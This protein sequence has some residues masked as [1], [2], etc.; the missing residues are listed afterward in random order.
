MSLKKI[1]KELGLSLTTVSRALN[2]YPEVA[3]STRL[4][5]EAAAKRHRYKPNA[6]A[7][8]LALGRADAIGLVF[9]ITPGDLGD[10]QFL[11]VA[12]SMS[13]RFAREGIDLLIISASPRDEL[14]AYE[15]AIKGRRIDAFV[16]AR[17]RVHDARLE[18]LLAHDVPFVAYG[19][20][21]ALQRPYAW[22]DFDNAAGAQM[23]AQRLLEFGHRRL[24]YLGAPPEYNFAEQR[25]GGF[26]AALQHAGVAIDDAA[27]LRLA[28]DRR[29]GYAAMQAL[30]ALPRRPSAVLVDNNLAG[31]GAVHA[32]LNAGLTLGR[33]LS[34]IVY[35]GLG[36]DSVI[37]SAITS[38]R[39]PTPSATG[40]E[41]AELTLARVRG[42]PLESLHRLKMPALDPGDSD[43]PPLQS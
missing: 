2:G 3:E 13:E 8:G 4:A 25:F 41:I 34:V 21:A 36:E 19:R 27:V 11:D 22:L 16:V 42:E 30:L 39:Q 5:V 14:A 38:I 35:D 29:S 32:L 33:D 31:V 7:R 12:A 43:G 24:G 10:A 37:R 18:L 6:I 40:T 9:P 15:R 20:S 17:T 23:A 1:A 26:Q 28:L